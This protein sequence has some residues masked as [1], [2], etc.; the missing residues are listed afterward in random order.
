MTK[1]TWSFILNMKLKYLRTVSFF[2]QVSCD[3]L[4]ALFNSL[5]VWLVSSRQISVSARNLN[6]KIANPE[7]DTVLSPQG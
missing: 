1:K 2:Q 5:C 4:L 3:A 7:S 6:G